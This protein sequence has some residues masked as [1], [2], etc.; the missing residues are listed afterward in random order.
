MLE[1]LIY[2]RDNFPQVTIQPNPTINVYNILN[3]REIVNFLFKH[4]LATD[5]DINLSNILVGPDY[6]SCTILPQELKDVAVKKLDQLIKD[7]DYFDMY[8]QRKEFL[9]D[10]VT[11][12]KN[13]LTSKDDIHLIHKFKDEMQKLDQI[14]NENF[15]KVFP[16]LKVLYD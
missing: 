15:I 11:N 12:I 8:P 3:L 4:N 6:L 5:Y 7:F 16:E 9:I 14:R 13:F 2:I 1:N 10:Q